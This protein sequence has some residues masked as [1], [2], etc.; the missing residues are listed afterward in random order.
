M[1]TLVWLEG[2][3]HKV[4][5]ASGWSYEPNLWDAVLRSAGISFVTGR[6]AGSAVQI[7][8]DG[9][10]VT[11]LSKNRAYNAGASALGW[12]N[13]LVG[14]VS[15]RIVTAPAADSNMFVAV[16]TNNAFFGMNTDG[17][18]YAALA[19]AKQST[20]GTFDDGAWH[21]I[22]FRFDASANTYVLDWQIDGADQTQ[23]TFGSTAAT[24][25]A[26]RFGS[27]AAGDNLTVQL[28]DAVFSATSGDYPLGEYKVGLLKPTGDGTHSL[29]SAGLAK[30]TGGTTDVW[31]V[32]DEIPP[33][34]T[35]YLLQANVG[36]INYLQ[37][38]FEDS[39]EDNVAAA[40]VIFCTASAGTPANSATT[41][42]T[43]AARATV[44]ARILGDYSATTAQFNS[45]LLGSVAAW[46]PSIANLNG[47]RGDFGSA[48]DATPD[49]WLGGCLIEYAVA[50]SAVSYTPHD[51]L[52]TTGFFGG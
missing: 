11:A 41:Q 31:D 29:G 25:T 30:S 40:R 1:A 10:T 8:E 46:T 47:L 12:T 20:G 19:S 32:I 16:A 14:S 22:D 4:A 7:V 42:I 45:H 2:F 18:V 17:T 13:L 50:I 15:F 6:V 35:D 23:V 44:Y 3:E 33:T 49:P 37:W 43:D 39:A 27:T 24:I 52:G 21:R 38:T 48:T 5:N 28:D 51:P 26:F 9:A 34:I 36:S